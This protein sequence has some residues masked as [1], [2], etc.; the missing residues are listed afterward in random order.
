MLSEVYALFGDAG[1]APPQ[2]RRLTRRFLDAW[3]RAARGEFPSWTGM[4][5]TDLGEDWNWVFAVELARS[6]GFPY[7][8]YLGQNLAKLSDVYLTG[9]TDWTLSLLDKATSEIDA[10]VAAEAPQMRDDMLTLCNGRRLM[11]R[12]IT[13]PLA[14]D[15]RSITHVVGVASGR[16]AD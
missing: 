8:I 11:F 15:G 9:D 6:A 14:D 1:V 13:A 10:A 4:R 16:F 5:A 3:T 2:D 12:S 7:F